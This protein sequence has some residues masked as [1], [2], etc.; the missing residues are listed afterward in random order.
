MLKM[1]IKRGAEFENLCDA[2]KEFVQEKI[3][4]VGKL[5]VVLEPDDLALLKN[6]FYDTGCVKFLE[7]EEEQARVL[8]LIPESD[9][10]VIK[11]LKEIPYDEMAYM[12]KNGDKMHFISKLRD[13]E[14]IKKILSG[15][16]VVNLFLAAYYIITYLF[17][18]EDKEPGVICEDFNNI[19]SY[20]SQAVFSLEGLLEGIY[21]TLTMNN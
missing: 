1:F 21:Y 13:D 3:A 15:L 14:K 10:C 9:Y 8:M 5:D 19:L 4:D 7:T 20:V 6:L 18:M 16:D 11:E 17:A 2:I 12:M